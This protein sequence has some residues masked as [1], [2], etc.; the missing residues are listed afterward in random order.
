MG[1]VQGLGPAS[2]SLSNDSNAFPSIL[3]PADRP[4]SMSG[5][6]GD[7]PACPRRCWSWRRKSRA[8][9]RPSWR[10][11]APT[12]WTRAW[13]WAKVLALLQEESGGGDEAALVEKARALWA[14]GNE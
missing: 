3:T 13:R 9:S 12:A 7:W 5:E 10:A 2:G 11:S 1:Y 4:P 8:S 14:K 6:R